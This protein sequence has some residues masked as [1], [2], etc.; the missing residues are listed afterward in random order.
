MK[1]KFTIQTYAGK[2]PSF[3]AG[4]NGVGEQ[5]LI[6]PRRNAVVAIAF[7][8]DG[9][10]L[11]WKVKDVSKEIDKIFAAPDAKEKDKFW[12]SRANVRC[13]EL[14][15]DTVNQWVDELGVKQEPIHVQ[16]FDIPEWGISIAQYPEFLYEY[17]LTRDDYPDE[18]LEDALQGWESGNM[19]KLWVGKDYDMFGDGTV[20]ST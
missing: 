5:F 3:L 20:E 7:H 11:G 16:E 6:C 19:F 13:A 14:M 1:K 12:G 4:K 10:P 17:K 15:N 2:P 18:E 9:Q 8:P